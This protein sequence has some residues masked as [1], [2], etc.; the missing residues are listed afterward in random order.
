MPGATPG[1]ILLRRITFI[2]KEV[3]LATAHGHV[4]MFYERRNHA[5]HAVFRGQLSRR[6]KI[7]YAKT[8]CSCPAPRGHRFPTVVVDHSISRRSNAYSSR[9]PRGGGAPCEQYP[10]R[11][12]V[13]ECRS[14]PAKQRQLHGQARY[15]VYSQSPYTERHGR[16]DFLFIS[17][18]FSLRRVCFCF[19]SP[20][21]FHRV[22][23]RRRAKNHAVA[24]LRHSLLP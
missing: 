10:K 12:V 16:K 9:S 17:F 14:C 23:I 15:G 18:I 7:A 11:G 2:S 8:G 22:L 4:L 24:S 5:A 6:P 20:L 1:G 19:G 21:I 13:R 3:L